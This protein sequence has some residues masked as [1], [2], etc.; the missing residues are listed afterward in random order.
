MLLALSVVEVG[1][2]SA[3]D[4]GLDT[5]GARLVAQAL[6]AVTLVGVAFALANAGGG[7]ATAAAL[8]LQSPSR[9]PI[10]ST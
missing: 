2:V 1:I 10:G 3:V 8:G 4:P 7:S 6:L 5:V 9:S